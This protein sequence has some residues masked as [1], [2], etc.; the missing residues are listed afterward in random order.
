[1]LS[2]VAILLIVILEWSMYLILSLRS[3]R[4]DFSLDKQSS[5]PSPD[6]GEIE[7]NSRRKSMKETVKDIYPA[8]H[9]YWG[10]FLTFN[11][12]II[13]VLAFIVVNNGKYPELVILAATA[14]IICLTSSA[15][16]FSNFFSRMISLRQE[17]KVFSPYLR[18]FDHARRNKITKHKKEENDERNAR[19]RNERWAIVLLILQCSIIIAIFCLEIKLVP[20]LPE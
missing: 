5:Q 14:I 10:S 4:R 17:G 11:A 20:Y 13:A 2:Y 7:L 9:A 3:Y 12:I 15:L 19:E 6:M 16:L 1:M 18:L 8:E